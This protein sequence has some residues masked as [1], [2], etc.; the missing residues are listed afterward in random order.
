MRRPAIRL[1]SVLK[2]PCGNAARWD[3][4]G[5]KPAMAELPDKACAVENGKSN[6]C[7]RQGKPGEMLPGQP[8]YPTAKA[9]WGPEHDGKAGVRANMPDPTLR[10]A[11][12]IWLKL[13]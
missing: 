2:S 10:K 1:R 6:P 7:L 13:H 8:S 11:R 4:W 9:S 5:Q 12:A 3:L